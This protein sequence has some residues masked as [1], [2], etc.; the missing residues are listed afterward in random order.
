LQVSEEYRQDSIHK[1]KNRQEH[2]I[3]CL[4]VFVSINLIKKGRIKEASNEVVRV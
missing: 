2:T 1:I 4:E 3:F